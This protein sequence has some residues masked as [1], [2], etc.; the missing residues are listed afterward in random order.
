MTTLPEPTPTAP[1]AG[2][3]TNPLTDAVFQAAVDNFIHES[4]RESTSPPPAQ[5]ETPAM[6]AR[7]TEITRAV[8]YCSLATVPPGLITVAVMVASEHAD[9]TVIGMICAA[10]AAV[11]VPVLALARLLRRAKDAMPEQHVHHYA[12]PVYQDQRNVH[13]KTTGLW[14]KTTNQ[15]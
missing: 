6:S 1:A 8:M 3:T 11:A 2:Q 15:Q 10:P 14:A 7:T 4:R 9:P 12:G 13:S 5:R